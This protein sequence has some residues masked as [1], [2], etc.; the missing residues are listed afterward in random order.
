MPTKQTKKQPIQ[1]KSLFNPTVEDLTFMYDGA[2]YI[3]KAGKVARFVDY[4]AVHGAKKLA[5][6]NIMTTNP[7]EHRVLMGAYL[8]N[9]DPEVIAKNL[10]I[11]L[12]KIRKEAMTKEKEKARVI[13][14]EAQMMEMREEIKALKAVKEKAPEVEKLAKQGRPPKKSK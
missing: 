5:D 7:E 1:F 2:E 8:E 3:V 11:D 13:N 9:S 4:I 14:L 6:K 12:E 10:G